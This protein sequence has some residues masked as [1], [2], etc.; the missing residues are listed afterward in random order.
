MNPFLATVPFD[1]Y[2][3]SLFHLVAERRS[4]TGAGR[5]AGLTQSAIT[6]QIR[7]LEE[8]LGL[9][10]F[11][12]TTRHVGLTPA[13]R[14]LYE[15]SKPI[16]ARAEA[17]LRQLQQEFRLVPQTLRI[18]VARSIGLAYLPG[19]LSAFRRRLP[20]VQIQVVQRDRLEIL[21][22]VEAGDLD[23]GLLSPPRRLP[24]ALAATHRFEDAFT[25]VVPPD[26]ALPVVAGPVSLKSLRRHLASERWLL[27][28]RAGQ[29]GAA[30]HRWLEGQ[31]LEVEPA[32]ELDSFD[33]IVNLVA[34]GLGV[35]LVPHRVLAL[36][37]SRRRVRRIAL[38]PRF[39]RELAVVAR[40]N[41]QQPE[42]LATFLD[43]ILFKS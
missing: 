33:M 24:S 43:C 38:R 8:Q 26:S 12:R 42:P 41:R 5:Q 35:S 16:V 4:F 18:G 9:A 2:E 6:R 25:L 7:G 30:L 21:A 19:F 31:G 39:T 20:A 14:T 27:L 11:E 34:L 10:L 3:L 37:G 29:T 40:K 17:M 1:L 36:Y 28:E 22:A 15:K 13:G 23:A 32:M